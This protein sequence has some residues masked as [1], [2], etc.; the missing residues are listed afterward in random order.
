MMKLHGKEY[1]ISVLPKLFLPDS[2]F[3]QLDFIRKQL[4]CKTYTE[5]LINITAGMYNILKAQEEY[6][7]NGEI[8]SPNAPTTEVDDQC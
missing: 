8:K 2:T 6:I 5:V 4:R 7:K 1:P 3:D